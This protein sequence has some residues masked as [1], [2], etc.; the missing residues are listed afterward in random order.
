MVI[1]TSPTMNLDESGVA[2]S[3][4]EATVPQTFCVNAAGM[5]NRVVA[6]AKSEMLNVVK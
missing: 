2:S 3:D 4:L 5:L 1:D 6:C